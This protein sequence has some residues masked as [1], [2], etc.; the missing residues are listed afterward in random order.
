MAVSNPPDQLWRDL[1]GGEG[2]LLDL[3]WEDWPEEHD[4]TTAPFSA[5]GFMPGHAADTGLTQVRRDMVPWRFD[6]RGFW[7]TD[8][9][10]GLLAFESV[11]AQSVTGHFEWEQ[12]LVPFEATHCPSWSR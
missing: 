7:T 12:Q 10:L 1:E 5:G 9:R 8:N 6:A 11:G 2:L 3:Y 4:L